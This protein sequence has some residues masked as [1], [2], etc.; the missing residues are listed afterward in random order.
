[1]EKPMTP[2]LTKQQGVILLL[3]TATALIH[4]YRAAVDPKI[5]D[6]FILNG[7]GYLTLGQLLYSR[8]PAITP[9]RKWV[10]WILLAYT[11]LTIIFY[12]VWVAMSGDWTLPW[13]PI[14]KVIEIALVVLLLRQK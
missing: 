13:G 1:M 10:R 14:D 12:F 5:S 6:L 7:L 8:L 11:A 3:I 9:Y 2:S 4:F